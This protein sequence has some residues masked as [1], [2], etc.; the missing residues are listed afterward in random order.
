MK[1]SLTSNVLD[2]PLFSLV[3]I[4]LRAARHLRVT[5]HLSR[6]KR[7]RIMFAASQGPAWA[8]L[9]SHFSHKSSLAHPD[10][11]VNFKPVESNHWKNCFQRKK[12][13][14]LALDAGSCFCCSTALLLHLYS[15]A[16]KTVSSRITASRIIRKQ[17][18][19][20][21]KQAEDWTERTVHKLKLS[22][23]TNRSIA[24][25]Q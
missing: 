15:G 10:T 3:G 22:R 1:P 2:E 25:K 6:L 8:A 4:F 7:P 11:H 19:N 18:Y 21:N 24:N 9:N 14:Q 17:K 5:K 16:Y 23:R 20:K 13:L 12:L